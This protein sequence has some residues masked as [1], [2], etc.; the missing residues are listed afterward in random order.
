MKIMIKK[1]LGKIL[2][3]GNSY[4]IDNFKFKFTN[5]NDEYGI[6]KETK[7]RLFFV[8]EKN[9]PLFIYPYERYD[10]MICKQFGVKLNQWQV[11]QM[12]GSYVEK[13]E[14]NST[15]WYKN[16]KEVINETVRFLYLNF[17]CTWDSSTDEYSLK[18]PNNLIKT[19]S[20]VF[21]QF[22]KF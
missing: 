13:I 8:D 20:Y 2:H 9:K 4:A 12:N 18:I 21:E 14:I 1:E 19:R 10:L 22:L 17:I 7:N 6:T 3:Y 16:E 15:V 11:L 5:L